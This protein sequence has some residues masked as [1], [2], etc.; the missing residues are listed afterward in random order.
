M[1]ESYPRDTL[2]EGCFTKVSTSPNPAQS[3][4]DFV[5]LSRFASRVLGM[6]HCA[7]KLIIP[8]WFSY[9]TIH[10]AKCMSRQTT[11]PLAVFRHNGMH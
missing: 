11:R 2:Q 7:Q 5:T 10:T 9:F 3:T 6:H 8:S 1:G 4:P